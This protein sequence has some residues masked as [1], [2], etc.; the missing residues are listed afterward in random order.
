TPF[1]SGKDSL[2]NEYAV[3]GQAIA[4]PGT[5]LISGLALVPDVRL[6]VTM[7]LKEPHDLLYVVG[8]TSDEMRCSYF[9]LLT[10][11]SQLSGNIPRVDLKLARRVHQALHR[12]IMRESVRACHDLSEGGLA[13]A[14]AEMAIA[15]G[16]G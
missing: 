2:N 16:R 6:C 8:Q 7:D 1:I 11:T 12:A 5:L 9:S 15:G 4:I 13:V 14:A 10:Q 3:G